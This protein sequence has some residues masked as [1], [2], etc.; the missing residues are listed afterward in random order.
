MAGGQ[1]GWVKWEVRRMYR[2]RDVGYNMGKYSQY[3]VITVIF[4]NCILKSLK[5]WFLDIGG[6]TTLSNDLKDAYLG[7]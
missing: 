3:S 4:K 7:P 6:T 2:L 1:Q 5:K